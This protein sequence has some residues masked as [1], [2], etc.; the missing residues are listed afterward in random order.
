MSYS[1]NDD[2][3]GRF[4]QGNVRQWAN[5]DNVGDTG[6]GA[7]AITTR[8][9]ASAVPVQALIDAVLRCCPYAVPSVG[10]AGTCDPLLSDL[11]A[12]LRGVW[13]YDPKGTGE[14]DPE[15][16][17]ANILSGLEKKM[18]ERLEQIRTGRLK[19]DAV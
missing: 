19:I 15:G 16:N 4:G 5:L 8:I 2:V 7:T 14:R 17:P 9:T 11:E 6:V 1:T 13:L 10:A 3:Y 12:T 18:M